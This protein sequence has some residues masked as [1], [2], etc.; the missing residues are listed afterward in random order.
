MP[1]P[2]LVALER[3]RDRYGAGAAA[4]KRALLLR[5]ARSRL[6]SASQV[7]RL[8]E[9]LCF[10]RAYPDNARLRAQVVR[11]LKAFAAR[12]DLRAQRDA[13]ENSGIA[14][15]TI[16]HAYFW[17]TLRWVARRWP[18]KVTIDRGDTLAARHIAATLGVLL[19]SSEAEWVRE[20]R[21]SGF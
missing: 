17:P 12:R 3:I 8:H 10:L 11:M 7:L 21:P 16:R 9:A 2:S 14:G 20:Q 18:R 4:R 13:L 19:T 5:L 6:R 1:A 15:T